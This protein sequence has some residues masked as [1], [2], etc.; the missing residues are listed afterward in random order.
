M[1]RWKKSKGNNIRL[2]AHPQPESLLRGPASLL[3]DEGWVRSMQLRL[4]PLFIS[5]LPL[6][7]LVLCSSLLHSPLFVSPP[8]LQVREEN[9]VSVWTNGSAAGGEQSL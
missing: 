4:P 7:S 6:P 2:S 8:P 9:G 5:P 1:H 3:C